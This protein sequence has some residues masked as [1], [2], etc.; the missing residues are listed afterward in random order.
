M[1]TT[2][3]KVSVC[4]CCWDCACWV[5]CCYDEWASCEACGLGILNCGACCWALCAPIPHKCECGKCS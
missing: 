1:S 5:G 3:N 4:L 2:C